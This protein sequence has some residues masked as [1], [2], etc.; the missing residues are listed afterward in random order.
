[1]CKINFIFYYVRNINEGS[2]NAILKF[3]FN[4]FNI[5]KFPEKQT[6]FAGLF[7]PI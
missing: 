1:M 6:Y 3:I 4:N 2:K 5:I 7:D